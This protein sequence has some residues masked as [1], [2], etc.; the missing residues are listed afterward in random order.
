MDHAVVSLQSVLIVLA[1]AVAAVVICRSLRL[2]AMIGYLVTGLALGPY[3]LGLVSSEREDTRLLAEIG[4]VFLMF[5]IGL[6]FS[7]SRLMAMRRV[8]FGLGAAQVFASLAIVMAL[9]VAAGW[10]WQAGLALG[11]IVAM[12]STAIVSK[13]L[14]E[15]SELDSPHGRHAE[16]LGIAV[17]AALA[18]AAGALAIVILAGPRLMRG[19]LGVVARRRSNELFVL[20]VLLVILLMAYLT[21]LAG[22]SMVLGAFLAG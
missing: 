20:N 18:K 17:A 8:V 15:R 21:G 14:A 11:G 16:A 13:L 5:S 22:L 3:A 9:S 4:V 6:E 7:L 1:C 2:P 10:G 19:W 12:S